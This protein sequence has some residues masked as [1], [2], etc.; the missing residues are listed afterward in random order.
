MGDTQSLGKIL[1]V[2]DQ[3]GIRESMSDALIIEGYE[4]HS[5]SNGFD[6]IK[7][8]KEVSFDVA[9]LDIKMPG[10][11]G[12]ETFVQIKKISPETVVFM[13]TANAEE[14]LLKQAIDEGAY[15]IIDKPFDM[16]MIIKVVADTQDKIAI[17]MI[18]DEKEFIDN[19]RQDLIKKGYK[20]VSVTDENQAK[21]SLARKSEEVVLVDVKG[22]FNSEE[23][24]ARI[25]NITGE[26][27]PRIIMINSNKAND[28]S[29]QL[30]TVG[31]KKLRNKPIDI[32]S[33]KETINGVLKE[34]NIPERSS[35]LIVENDTELVNM[36]L[37]ELGG[38][39]FDVLAASDCA[40]A[41]EVLKK[42]DFKLV[43]L[44]PALAV[45]GCDA[46]IEKLAA[47]KPGTEIFVL[48]VGQAEDLEKENLR[49][50]QK[51]FGNDNI[52]GLVRKICEEKR[53]KEKRT[54][55]S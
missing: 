49:F 44:S 23:V 52:I 4:V 41:A 53:R 26:E 14:A 50:I 39:G 45:G 55:G 7:K 2:D 35:I 22:K 20:V 12:V 19:T 54:E 46:Q 43:L 8:A 36:L 17:L 3:S 33:I 27:N 13:I 34:K 24:F 29:G 47:E 28:D 1:I 38:H 42:L 6:A 31:T 21:A 30:I 18:D 11:N 10:I 51:P 40:E 48:P 5:F 15:A 25:K 37:V 9:F 32:N 16:D